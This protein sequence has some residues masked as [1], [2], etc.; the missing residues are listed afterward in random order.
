MSTL[1]SPVK[2]GRQVLKNR[3]V[4][5]PMTRCRADG[6]GVPTDL[7]VTYYGQRASAGLI[8]SEATAT[9][10]LG[11]GYLNIPG[12]YTD[13]QTAAWR[14][15]TEAVHAAGGSIYLQIMHSGRI[16]HPSLLPDGAR[17]VAPSAIKAAGQIF[18]AAGLQDLV[19]PR[20][21]ATDEVVE[22]VAEYGEAARR[23]IEAGF[24]G[25]ELHAA[26][27]YLPEQFLASG[28]NRREDRYGGTLA[29][30][31]RF[32][33]EALEA[34]IAAVGADRVGMKIAP[35]MGFNDLHDDRPTE[36]YPYLVEQASTLGMAYLHVALFGTP[37]ADYHAL[38]RP[39]FR[40]AYLAGGGL[41]QGTAEA[42]LESGIA[43]AVVFGAA[44]IAN[45]DLPERM[46]RGVPL[47]APDPA[48]YYT[49]GPEGYLDYPSLDEA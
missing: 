39:R 30:R 2:I 41:A 38:L 18:T 37:S 44:F 45:P 31:A 21:L 47:K 34:M 24:D 46:R 25:V 27:G 19:E 11:K 33:L 26:S 9:S 5:A 16:G 36:T 29:N 10:A 35:E 43:D 49:P 32:A 42:L 22:I 12:I 4:M 40:G 8:L 28:T 23:A 48:T 15:V 6:A 17:P 3:L 7:M 20:A 1:F 14:P 13:A